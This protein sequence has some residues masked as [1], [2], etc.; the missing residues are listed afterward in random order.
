MTHQDI[1]NELHMSN[2]D[3]L[4]ADGFDE[5]LIGICNRYGQPSL[6][7]YDYEK[8][9]KILMQDGI[10]YEEAKEYFEFNILGAWVGEGTPVF[11]QSSH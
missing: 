11:I 3:A 9:I 4:L 7:A 6:A 8:C 10:S 1:I 2:P 5:A